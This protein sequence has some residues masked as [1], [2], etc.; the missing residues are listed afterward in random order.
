MSSGELLVIVPSR[1]RPQS[2]ARL[3]DAV[4]ATSRAVTHLHVAVDEDDETLPLYE[5]VMARAGGAGDTLEPGPRRDL[6]GWTNKIAVARA[7]EYPFLAS[8]GDDHV[9]VTP[10]WDRAL[11]R[12]ISTAGGT[13]FAY[14]FDGTRED[15]PEAV[16]MSSDI[17]AALGWMC[18]PGLSHWYVDCVWADLGRAIG[19][20][21]YL[22]AV[23][24]EHVRG[25]ADLTAAQS[26]EHLSADRDAYYRW[27]KTAMAADIATVTARREKAAAAA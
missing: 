13:G 15:I 5:A 19:C 16:V 24:V 11:V 12:A 3:L 17:V 2:I 8:F 18:Q 20:L 7:A 14:P 26:G 21:R 23:K 6:A 9:P 27:R 25:K 22:R 10:G 1:G 4:H